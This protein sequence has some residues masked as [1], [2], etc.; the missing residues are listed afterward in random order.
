[1]NGLLPSDGPELSER[2]RAVALSSS[3]NPWVFQNEDAEYYT[4]G[5][6]LECLPV[7]TKR[8]SI[9]VDED[10]LASCTTLGRIELP[11]EVCTLSM[12]VQK[13]R[14]REYTL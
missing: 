13:K 8:P 9:T 7:P 10:T 11:L 4:I 14:V 5:D 2:A 3:Q 6:S 1:M 12:H